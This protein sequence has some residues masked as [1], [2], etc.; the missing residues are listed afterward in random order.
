MGNAC[1]PAGKTSPP[2]GAPSAAP[3][4]AEENVFAEEDPRRPL[5]LLAEK[6]RASNGAA[7]SSADA[8]AEL[9]II[10]SH[11]GKMDRPLVQILAA[12]DIRLIG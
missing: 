10:R 6:M 9:E 3:A 5:Q 4:A 7:R 8:A 11:L 2:A 12:G 1:R